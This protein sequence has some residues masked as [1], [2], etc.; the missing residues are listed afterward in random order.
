VQREL[1]NRGVY[2]RHFANLAFGIGDCLRV[3][4]GTTEENEIFAN[5]LEAILERRERAA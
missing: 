2:V 1:G 3:S 4:I 5:E